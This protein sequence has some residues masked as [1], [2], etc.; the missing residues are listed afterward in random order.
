[1]IIEAIINWVITVLQYS[2][3]L[4]PGNGQMFGAIPSLSFSA[5]KFITLLNGYLPINEIG[6]VFLIMLAVYAAM[7]GIR[8]IF[9]IYSQISKLIP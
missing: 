5:L 9:G 2:V 6:A 1:M 8:I 4:L 3:S 7:F